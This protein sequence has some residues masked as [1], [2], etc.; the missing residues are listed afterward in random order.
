MDNINVTNKEINMNKFGLTMD[1]WE[2]NVI[3]V[4]LTHLKEMHE[5]LKD[6]TPLLSESIIESC[7]NLLNS[8]K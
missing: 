4:A 5:D 7:E 3:Q 1:A 8:I 2:R 6:E